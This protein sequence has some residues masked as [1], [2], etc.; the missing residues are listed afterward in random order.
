MDNFK[1]QKVVMVAVLIM[2]VVT[3]LVYFYVDFTIEPM[4]TTAF[5]NG[6]KHIKSF[7]MVEGTITILCF[8]GNFQ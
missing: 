2:I 1:K 6:I 3:Y 5:V 7:I 4:N 8:V